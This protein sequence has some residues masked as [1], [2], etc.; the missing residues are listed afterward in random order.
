MD[1]QTM[2]INLEELKQKMFPIAGACS[3]VY[4]LFN[5]NELVYVGEG[6]NCFLRVAEHTRKDK[7]RFKEFTGWTFISIDDKMKR[8]DL[9]KKI[10]KEIKTK[11]NKI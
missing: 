11:Y 7:K 3:G 6:W 5:K 1:I 10:R 8:K 2:S 4:F 9:E